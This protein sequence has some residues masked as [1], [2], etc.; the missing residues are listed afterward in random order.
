MTY[1]EQVEALIGSFPD[2]A[3]I[4]QWL[5]DSARQLV[6]MIPADR[7]T[8]YETSRDASG[9]GATVSDAR[10]V[11][12][13]RNDYGCKELSA[14]DFI[15]ASDGNSLFYAQ[16][17]DPVFAVQDGKVNIAPNSGSMEAWVVPYPVVTYSDETIANFPP[18]FDH[19]VVLRTAVQ[20]QIRLMADE[21]LELPEAPTS[22]TFTPDVVTETTIGTNAAFSIDLSAQFTQLATYLNTQEDIELARTTLEEIVT[23]LTE[24]EKESGLEMVRVKFNA[25]VTNQTDQFNATTKL[26]AEIATFTQT[27]QG[28]AAVVGALL[29]KYQSRQLILN[30]L[31]AEYNRCLQMY[32]GVGEKKGKE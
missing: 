31:N 13:T 24:F 11:R 29:Q 17:D 14:G 12:A 20:A 6:N 18:D 21:F 16:T 19:L 9:A 8:Q 7:V 4:T 2:E 10:L 32:F 15:K 30:N 22:P 1:R 28:Y 3:A 25:E 23:R 5:T 27:L 26:Q